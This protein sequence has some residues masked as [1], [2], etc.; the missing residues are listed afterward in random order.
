[1]II[2]NNLQYYKKNFVKFLETINDD[3]IKEISTLI[4]AYSNFQE[5]KY[6]SA[7]KELSSL[8]HKISKKNSKILTLTDNFDSQIKD[9]IKRFSEI[10]YL[11]EYSNFKGFNE[12]ILPIIKA[13]QLSQKLFY[14]LLY[15]NI[16]TL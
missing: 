2:H 14:L 16:V 10:S 7:M 3:E 8:I 1:M 6:F 4:L 15:V 12:N 5:G 13:K 11:N 9:M